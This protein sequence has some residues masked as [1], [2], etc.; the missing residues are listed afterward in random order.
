[1]KSKLFS[2]MAVLLVCAAL[3][4]LTS[5]SQWGNPYDALDKEGAAVSV[6]YI[7]D[8]A[9][10][11]TENPSVGVFANTNGVTVVNVYDIK[12]YTPNGNG[13]VEITLTEPSDKDKG[14]NSFSV[15]KDGHILAG[16]FI[17]EPRV[18]A[19][20]EPLDNDGNLVSESGKAQGYVLGERW[21]FSLD[22]LTL[23]AEGEYTS[24]R[25]ELTLVAK[26]MPYVSFE[27]YEKV[28]D[29]VKLLGT[30]EAMTLKLPEW[31]EGK[32][33]YNTTFISVPGKTFKAAY[34]DEAMTDLITENVTG[35][36]N[37]ETGELETKTIR[38]YTEWIDGE[39]Y[40]VENIKQF[41]DYAKKGNIELLADLDF[42]N[43]KTVW[44]LASSSFNGILEGNGHTI[45]GVNSTAYVTS[46]GDI[47][48][49][50]I[51]GSLGKDA[52]IRNVTF[53]DIKYTVVS[54]A[55]ASNATFGLFAGENLGATI[56]NV[57]LKNSVLEIKKS[58]IN[59]F[60]SKIVNNNF[61]VGLVIPYGDT[62]G[63]T[64]E[65]VV[66]I[67]EDGAEATVHD[68]LGVFVFTY[69]S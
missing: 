2:I 27:F 26:W 5:C 41:K 50:G 22:K 53:S 37:Y 42:T 62:S 15:S 30:K 48:H 46:G 3:M 12:K 10:P 56:E 45:K 47:S 49:G 17:A 60:K 54:A 18:N 1:M 4:S 51:F 8:L 38:I 23:D 39:W 69:Q 59:D 9:E 63:I 36:Y 58:F 57:T 20:G 25:P 31:K 64:T 19:N 61:V 6:K 55:K 40:K 28:G 65:N 11:T 14:N 33:D 43:E 34:L 16:W 68:N 13:K 35:V 52:I 32:L 24:S 21:D 67:V 44:A 7:A 29:E 66:Y